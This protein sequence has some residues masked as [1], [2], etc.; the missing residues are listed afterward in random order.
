V[1]TGGSTVDGR[2]RGIS[3]ESPDNST[4]VV[5][6]IRDNVVSNTFGTGPGGSAIGIAAVVFGG[7]AVVEHNLVSGVTPGPGGDARG[8]QTFTATE[9]FCRDNTVLGAP[10]GNGI[11]NCTLIA[12]NYASP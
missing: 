7:A 6:T 1:N 11:S 3:A 5:V 8:I 10:P 12:D 2:A 9:G 4:P